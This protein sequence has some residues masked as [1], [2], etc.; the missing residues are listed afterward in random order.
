[1]EAM[2]SG[3]VVA[4]FDT[5]FNREVLGKRG[6]FFEDFA[7]ELPTVLRWLADVDSDTEAALR[8]ANAGRAR[9]RFDLTSVIDAYE[10]LLLT[11]A[12]R[13]PSTTVSVDT[14]WT[15]A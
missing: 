2:G 4:A 3:A 11:V 7:E 9:D 10:R 5:A 12:D 13:S 1:V 14:R 15:A 8:R 6:I